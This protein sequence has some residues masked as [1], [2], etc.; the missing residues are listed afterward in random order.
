MSEITRPNGLSVECYFCKKSIP[1]EQHVSYNY[2]DNCDSVSH[3]GYPECRG[4]EWDWLGHQYACKSCLD[5][6]EEIILKD[7]LNSYSNH[8]DRLPSFK[9]NVKQKYEIEIEKLNKKEEKLLMLVEELRKHK[10]VNLNISKE[11]Q[12][13]ISDEYRWKDELKQLFT[14]PNKSMDSAS[15]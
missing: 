6:K 15:L 14:S 9:E 2:H 12:E 8:L 1:A 13:I 10:Q 3:R 11:V 5:K 7:L 4:I